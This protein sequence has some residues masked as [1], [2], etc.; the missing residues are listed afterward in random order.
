MQQINLSFTA[1]VYNHIKQVGTFRA[2]CDF[3]KVT[4]QFCALWGS[5]LQEQSLQKECP[6]FVYTTAGFEKI[7]VCAGRAANY[8]D[9]DI[10]DQNW[11]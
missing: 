11:Q 10:D 4:D 1:N 3:M 8:G 9:K 2:N 6:D 7:T 5:C